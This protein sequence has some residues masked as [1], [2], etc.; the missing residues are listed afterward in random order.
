[1]AIQFTRVLRT[2]HSERFLLI[3]DRRE[4]AAL[5]LHYL[6]DGHVAGTLILFDGA[7]AD[8]ASVGRLLSQIDDQ[9]LPE[10]SIE[11]GEI[12]FTVVVG[13]VLATFRPQQEN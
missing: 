2:P 4:F 9:L 11:S 13:R 5:D 1:M 7:A 12:A 8:E 10:A 3:E 6:A